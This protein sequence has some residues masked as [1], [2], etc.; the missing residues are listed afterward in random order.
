[1]AP[2]LPVRV[3]PGGSRKPSRSPRRV[4]ISQDGP[5]SAGDLLHSLGFESVILFENARGTRNRNCCLLGALS[6]GAR[7]SSLRAEAYRTNAGRERAV[8]KNGG[9]TRTLVLFLLFR[10]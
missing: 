3:G 7:V 1:M 4:S 2:A 8:T 5:Q 6:I 10:F 9:L